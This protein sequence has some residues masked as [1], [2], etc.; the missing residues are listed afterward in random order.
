[1]ANSFLSQGLCTYNRTVLP[2]AL[3][4]PLFPVSRAV[5]VVVHEN[6]RDVGGEGILIP[7]LQPRQI[8]LESLGVEPSYWYFF[9]KASQMIL[10]L[11]QG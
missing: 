9:F 2:P 7:R 10:I 1:M 5:V 6:D 3:S 11:S 8:K 4:R